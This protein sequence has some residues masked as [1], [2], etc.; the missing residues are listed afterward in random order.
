ME[1]VQSRRDDRQIP[2]DQV[3]VAD[4]RCPIVVF[5][6]AQERQQTVATFS[7][8]VSLPHHFKGTHMSRFVELL[9]EHRGEMTMRTLR[10]VLQELKSRL[11]A[12][13]A[14]IEVAFPY[15]VERHAPVTKA[16]AVM[17]YECRFIGESN[18]S[19]DDFIL[20]V[21]VPVTSLCP[22]SKSISKY[23]GHNQRGY[24]TIAVRSVPAVDGRPELI[25]IEELIEVAEKAA[26][27]PVYPILK[28]P[29]EK[30][31]TEQ[32]Y[33]N[34]MFVEDMTRNVAASLRAD[35]RVAWFHVRVENHESIHNHSVF[36]ELEWQRR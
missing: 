3:G 30:F 17:D 21:T 7:M 13:K 36:A 32:A 16:S 5:D 25:W 35:G 4:L 9:N 15:F 11:V 24:I 33:D 27:A 12:E 23:G 34:P 1:D 26:S 2:I 19:R 28:R 6:R 8:S 31:V 10:Q 22:C 20:E 14:R 29:D 18:G